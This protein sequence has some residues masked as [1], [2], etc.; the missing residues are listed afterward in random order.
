M[1]QSLK[2]WRHY[3]IPKVFNLYTH[4][5]AFKFITRKENLNQKHAKWVD[6]MQSFTFVLKHISGNSNKV[7]DSLSRNC[8]V[9]QKL[10]VGTLG[11]EHL[12]EMYKEDLEFRE[13]YE[14]CENSV[15]RDRTP[16]IKYMIQDGQ[17][18]IRKT[19]S[20]FPTSKLSQRNQ[21]KL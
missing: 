20:L 2:K 15:L 13:T 17:L 12:K 9:F 18:G 11:F 1:I 21:S 7:G 4:N 6:F 19:C 5:H 14:A 16:W 10:Q 8:L 3:L